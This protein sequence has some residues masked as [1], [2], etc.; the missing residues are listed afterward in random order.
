MGDANEAHK[1]TYGFWSDK[2]HLK[3]IWDRQGYSNPIPP[4]SDYFT[5][6]DEK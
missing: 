1:T 2:K 5:P 6:I 3:T 4:F